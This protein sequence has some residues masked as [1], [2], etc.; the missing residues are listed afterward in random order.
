MAGNSFGERFRVTTFG[1]SHG[2]GLGVVIDGC[3]AGFPFPHEAIAAQ[4][5]RR[6]P[7][8]GKLSTQ[9]QEADAFELLSGVDPDSGHTLGTPITLVIRNKDAR[10]EHYGDLARAYRPSHADYSYDARYGLRAIGGGG[11]SSAR[12]TIGRVAAGAL[13]EELLRAPRRDRDRRLG[14]LGRRH[15][16][17]FPRLRNP[18]S[19]AGRCP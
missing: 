13:A 5:A 15:R 9:R 7:G 8:Q 11:R 4:L 6:R 10:S 2:G 19:Q 18:R 12:E 16:C 17:P 1:E 3:P 14:E